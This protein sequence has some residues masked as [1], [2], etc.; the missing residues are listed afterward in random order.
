MKAP[1]GMMNFNLHAD[2]IIEDL[3]RILDRLP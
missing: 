3:R 2:D 1:S